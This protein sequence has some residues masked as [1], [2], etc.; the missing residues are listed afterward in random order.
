MHDHWFERTAAKDLEGVMRYIADDIVAYEHDAPL[1]HVGRGQ[2]REVCRQGLDWAE[3]PVTWD[4][5]DMRVLIRDDLAVVWGLNRMTA[6][7]ADGSVEESW[8]RGTR[9]L[10][11]RDGAWVMIHQHVSFPYDARTGQ[12]RTDLSP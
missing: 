12:A 4:V 7:A 5:P 3:G 10:Q 9:V 8:S 2:V 1:Q 11:R 6:Q